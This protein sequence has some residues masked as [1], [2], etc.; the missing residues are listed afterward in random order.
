MKKIFLLSILAA[1]L[2]FT[3]M[4]GDIETVISGSD[5][6]ITC[7]GRTEVKD[8][9][10]SFDWTGTYI[11][12]RFQG[13][14]LSFK[15]S[16]T[17]SNYYNV[18]LDAESMAEKPLKKLTVTGKD[19]TI[20]IFS[21][22]EMLAAV[23]K[24]GLKAP[25]QVIL[26]K[27]TEGFRGIT[28]IHSFI[29]KG[30]F[31]QADAPKE[32]VIEF[33]GD[34]YTCGYGTEAANTEKFSP[35]TENQNLTYA[36]A[37]ARYFDAELIAVAHSGQGVA[38]NYDGPLGE[39][40]MAGRYLQ[41]YDSADEPKWDAKS[42][43]LKPAITVIYLGTNDFSRRMQPSQKTFR[44]NYHKLL[45]E[46][47]DNYGADHPIICMSSKADE[48]MAD[49]VRNAAKTCGMSNVDF[50]LLG[51]KIH[52]NDSDMGADGHPNYAGQI[53]VAHNL[54]PYVSTMTGWEMTG[55]PI[56]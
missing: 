42:C 54:I 35:E 20:V 33:I 30:T 2:S 39:K 36:C 29:T 44:E 17:D 49:Y 23:G 8:G 46:V 3:A 43:A 24:K 52:N 1:A 37:T 47:K 15:V 53:K 32:R 38:R 19:T 7:I 5:P 4:A 48:L 6:L 18:W 55:N 50:V 45:K 22:E 16:D 21:P 13:D 56:R 41:T 10:I 9:A 11:K 12:V 25:H 14:R 27:R 28:T 34:S 40:T 51:D 26:Q 31:L